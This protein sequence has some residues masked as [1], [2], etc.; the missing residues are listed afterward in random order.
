[1]K[2]QT[3]GS[4]TSQYRE[5]KKPIGISLVAASENESSPNPRIISG[6]LRFD[7]GEQFLRSNLGPDIILGG[8]KAVI[9]PN[10]S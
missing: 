2:K 9:V 1:M 5:E 4:E 10:E 7:L 8:R 3:S 6:F